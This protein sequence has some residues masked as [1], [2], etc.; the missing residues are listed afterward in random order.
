MSTGIIQ[1][2]QIDWDVCKVD[3]WLQSEGYI[4]NILSASLRAMKVKVLEYFIPANLTLK[5]RKWKHPPLTSLSWGR[6]SIQHILGQ[7][8]FLRLLSMSFSLVSNKK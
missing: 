1:R 7:G 6:F 5:R 2:V 8:E 3:L 4:H